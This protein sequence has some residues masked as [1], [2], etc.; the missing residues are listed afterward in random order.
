MSLFDI[1]KSIGETLRKADKI[2]EYQKILDVQ[3]KLLEMQKKIT[4]LEEENKS[5]KEKLKIKGNLIFENNAYWI[6]KGGS[7]KDGPFCSRCWDKNNEL[8][9]MHP[10]LNPAF[11]RCPE[12]KNSV[13]VRPDLDS[14][15]NTAVDY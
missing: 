15:R 3:E 13:Q 4:D 9:R 7:N 6:K 14:Y 2:E 12:C 11:Y 8:I 1:L 10:C 5:L